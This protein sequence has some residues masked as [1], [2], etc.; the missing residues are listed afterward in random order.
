MKWN[1]LCVRK[2][3]ILENLFQLNT[4]KIW[5]KVFGEV[6]GHFDSSYQ[7]KNLAVI[8]HNQLVIF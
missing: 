5:L 3:A 6:L 8:D 4:L 1:V 2:I 7:L